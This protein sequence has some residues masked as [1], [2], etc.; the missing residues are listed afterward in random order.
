MLKV[1][2][3]DPNRRTRSLLQTSEAVDKTG[4]AT[5]K[6][7]SARFHASPSLLGRRSGSESS[8]LVCKAKGLTGADGADSH[9]SLYL[10][11]QTH[12]SRSGASS[13]RRVTSATLSTRPYGVREKPLGRT[14]GLW[15]NE[16]TANTKGS[17]AKE[18]NCFC[19]FDHS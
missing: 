3:A 6:D 7:P 5:A 8:W 9:F 1:W 2:S 18:N 4:G 12:G 15:H 13:R 10:V 19:G 14:A 16:N 11:Q 17:K